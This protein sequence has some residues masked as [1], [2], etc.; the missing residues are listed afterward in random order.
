VK[1]VKCIETRVWRLVEARIH[2]E[3]GDRLA[4]LLQRGPIGRVKIVEDA[5]WLEIRARIDA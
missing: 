1:S 3:A 2:D 4:L 5:V